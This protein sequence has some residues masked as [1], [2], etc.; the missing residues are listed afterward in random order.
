[1]RKGYRQV[2]HSGRNRKDQLTYKGHKVLFILTSILANIEDVGTTWCSMCEEK[3]ASVV[4]IGPEMNTAILESSL[5]VCLKFHFYVYKA[6]EQ[7]MCT[8]LNNLCIQ[9]VHSIIICNRYKR[10]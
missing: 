10:K 9:V 5:T 6:F 1:M 4:R 7:C 8:H 2:I 3:C